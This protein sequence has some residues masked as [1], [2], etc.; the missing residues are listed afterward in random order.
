MSIKDE[1]M[2]SVKQAMRAKD[3]P[4][5]DALR[6]LQA[7]IRQVEVDTQKELSDADVLKILQTEAKKRK[8]SI[9]AFESG[10]R[11][12]DADKEQYELELIE[13]YLPE[14]MSE[15]EITVIVKAA[16]EKTGA[17]SAQDMGK[18][19]GVIMPQVRGKADG[20]LVNQIVRDLLNS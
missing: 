10:G 15:A 7:A 2:Q 4:R 18:L 12:D 9:E 11:Q 14:Q 20:K 17:E 13:V 6:G 16:I 3:A 1:I 8:E 5:R 19:M